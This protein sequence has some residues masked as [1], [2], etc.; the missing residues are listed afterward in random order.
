[1]TTQFHKIFHGHKELSVRYDLE[2]EAIWCYFKPTSR[3][4]FS[5]TLLQESK[6][7]QNSIINY[8]KTIEKNQYPVRYLVLASQTPGVFNLGGDLDLFVKL[9]AEQ[10]RDRLLDYATSCVDICYFNAIGLNLPLTTISLVQGMA[11]GGGFESAMSSNVLIAEE[12]AK[13][14]APEIR[15]NLFPGMGGY[16]FIARKAG[17]N[18]ADE[19]LQSGKIYSAQEMLD[20]KIVNVIAETGKGYEAVAQYIKNH[21]RSA[22][23]MRAI[24]EVKQLYNPITHEELMGITKIWVEAALR[25]TDK[26]IRVMKRLVSAQNR[27]NFDP[28]ATQDKTHILR[29]K[30]DRRFDLGKVTYPLIDSAGE[31]I[32]LDRRKKNRRENNELQLPN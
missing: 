15:F 30:Q 10:N 19:V 3:P 13:M 21:K 29:T 2:Q 31:T 1:M 9:I 32:L 6:A 5:P 7:I 26:D 8:F 16:S 18:A 11:L 12:Q 22:N 17:M 24:Q 20:L 4:C 25:L 27:G 14:G 28:N 23:G